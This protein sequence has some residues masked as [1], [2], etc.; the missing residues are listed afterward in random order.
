MTEVEGKTGRGAVMAVGYFKR[1]ISIE[2]HS[3]LA[4]MQFR[5]ARFYKPSACLCTLVQH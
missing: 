5:L 1:I 3:P 4:E 2:L